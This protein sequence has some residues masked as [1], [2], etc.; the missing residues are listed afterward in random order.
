MEEKSI[1]KWVNKDIWER[2]G[3]LSRIAYLMRMGVDN[4]KAHSHANMN[5]EDLPDKLKNI[6]S[7]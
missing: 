6:Y 7:K 4:T 1:F 5:Y 2:L 3:K